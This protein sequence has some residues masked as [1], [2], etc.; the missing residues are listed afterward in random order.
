LPKYAD[1]ASVFIQNELS[2]SEEKRE[3]IAY[4][5][6]AFTST[7]LCFLGI[8]LFGYLF[9]FLG[10]VLAISLTAALVK[11]YTG[12]PHCNTMLRCI[13]VTITIFMT[14]S[15][16]STS[17]LVP[18]LSLITGGLVISLILIARYAPV[19]VKQKPLS[20]NHKKALRK[21]TFKMSIL[22]VSL[23]GLLYFFFSEYFA[24]YLVIGFLWMGFA[25]TPMG[26]AIINYSDKFLKFFE[27][28]I[29]K[30]R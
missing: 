4:G 9:S 11:I 3:V 17:F 20:D 13:I 7:V 30:C 28:S 15:Y 22:F 19:E 21:G 23:V 29:I 6:E 27:D 10:P 14:L 5:V 18:S 8:V 12:G 26:F 24:L 16:I 2:L 25:I 1:K